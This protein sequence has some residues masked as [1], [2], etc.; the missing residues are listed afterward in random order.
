MQINVNPEMVFDHNAIVD[1]L[2]EFLCKQIYFMKG[3]LSDE[4]EGSYCVGDSVLRYI[5]VLCG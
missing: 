4:K 3:M 5:G 2:S 1:I